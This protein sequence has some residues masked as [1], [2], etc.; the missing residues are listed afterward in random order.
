MID[1]KLQDRVTLVTG[2]NCGIGAAVAF[3]LAVHGAKVVIT[4]LRFDAEAYR[5]DSGLPEEYGRERARSG[6]E[7]VERIRN[8]GG[9]ASSIE[10][11]LS[12]SSAISGLFDHAET[13]FGPVEILIHSASSWLAN[14]FVPSA[15]DRF[16]RKLT[17]VSAE[18]HDK[19]F[20]V[21]TRAG[22][23]LIAEFS[24]RHIKRGANW[25]RII[26][27]TSGGPEGFP[28]EVSYGAAKAALENYIHSAAYELGRFGITANLVY[29]PATDTGWITPEVKKAVLESSPFT[30]VG[31][32]DEVA[33]VV[34]YLSSHQAR[35]VTGN[36]IR[37]Y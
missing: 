23:L 19:Q 9:Q 32:P 15:Q 8:S 18:S 11:D 17:E 16:G 20:S 21:D 33:E 34:C 1:P 24:R 35:Y 37:M 28:Q 26:A 27:L 22:A 30:H 7:V 5:A 13:N 10:A 25:G 31:K 29:P 14:T 36:I 4:Y 3:N 12:D 6:E 2:A